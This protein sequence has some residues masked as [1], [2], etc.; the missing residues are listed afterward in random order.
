MGGPVEVNTLS[1]KLMF[2]TVKI[3]SYGPN[4]VSKGT[5]FLLNIDRDPAYMSP[6]LVTN[7]HVVAGATRVSV[8]FIKADPSDLSRPKLGEAF[9]VDAN[10]GK[11][12]GHPDPGVDLTMIVLGSMLTPEEYAGVYVKP[13]P[14]ALIPESEVF[15]AFD[16]LE[17][18]TFVGYPNGWSDSAHDTPI[19]RRGIT[20]TP[21]SLEFDGRPVFLV[22]GSVFGGSS[23]SPV[24]VFNQA[25]YPDGQGT[26]IMGS[27]LHLVGVMAETLI[28][29]TRLPLSVSTAPFARL[30]QEMNL[31]VAFGVRAIR[32]AVEEV[33]RAHGL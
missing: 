15:D 28:R 31:G 14:L 16:A 19:I 26:I 18:V 2:A 33:R 4:G 25:G 29:D 5:G 10:P 20:A 24:F 27:R 6:V 9:D 21:M 17:E 23:G 8:R 7:K 13:L 11:F 3:T 30:S 12:V 1:K 32:E 22:D